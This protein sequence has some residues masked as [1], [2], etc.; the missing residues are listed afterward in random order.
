MTATRVKGVTAALLLLAAVAASGEVRITFSVGAWETEHGRAGRYLTLEA[1]EGPWALVRRCNDGRAWL[2]G[3]GRSERRLIDPER[4][5]ADLYRVRV[6]T[7]DGPTFS[8]WLAYQWNGDRARLT[9]ARVDW[10]LLG[11]TLRV[12]LGPRREVARFP[13]AG[14]ASALRLC[15]ERAAVLRF[16]EARPAP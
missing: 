11:E 1:E 3:T 14:F 9:L 12:E 8:G 15:G 6:R 7:D 16:G 5:Q 13:T 4:R 2:V 10:L